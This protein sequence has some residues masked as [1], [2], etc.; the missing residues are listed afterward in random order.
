MKML[1]ALAATAFAASAAITTPASAIT[2][3]WV[4]DNTH[5]Y[6][7]LAVFYDQN[8]E[9]LQRCSGTLISATKFLTAGH[10]TVSEDPDFPVTSARIYFQQDAGAHYDPVTQHDPVSGY[11]DDCAGANATPPICVTSHSIHNFNYTNGALP[12]T[13]DVGLLILDQRARGLG[14]GLLPAAGTLDALA[15]AR[16][17]QDTVF[18][19]SGYGLT[20]KP[21]AQ[22]GKPATSFR[23]RLMAEAIL[24]N[25]SSTLNDGYNLQTQGNGDDLG[26]TCNGDSGGPVFLG[27]LTS[28]NVIVAVTS[29]G[30]NLLCRGTDF[31]YRIDRQEVLDWI[32]SF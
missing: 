10:C 9:F 27:H 17:T 6:V 28:S 12:D 32:N 20:Y 24:T 16:G 14:V 30:L 3:D 18:T 2:G 5:T 31:A 21:Q 15:T 7:G 22:S 1:K 25:L 8:G 29:F 13:H 23:S 19:V 26:G 11:P 4:P